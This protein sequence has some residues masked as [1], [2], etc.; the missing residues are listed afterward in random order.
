MPN[1]KFLGRVGTIARFKPLH[2]AGARM[3][4]ALCEEADQVV[5]GLG[6]ANK[7]NL[8][9]PF[10]VKESEAMVRAY[11]SS[12][13]DNYECIEIPDFAQMPEYKD[14]QKWREYIVKHLGKLDY[15]I[16]GNP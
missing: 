1:D 6:S 13:Y 7:Y 10:T 2:L 8:R 3:L 11:L 14:G 5:I 4:E 15:F 9:N 12:A 16:T